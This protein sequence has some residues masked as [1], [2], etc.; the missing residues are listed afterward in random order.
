MVMTQTYF[1]SKFPEDLF[2]NENDMTSWQ[3]AE[4][5]FEGKFD[6]QKDTTLKLI[7]V[8]HWKPGCFILEGRTKDKLGRDVTDI[9][10]FTLFSE[11][12]KALPYPQA[13]WFVPVKTTCEPGEKAVFLVG[14]F[15][16]KD[17]L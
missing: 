4:K 10:Y 7:G 16:R 14:I 5:I 17:A 13:D 3:K 6:T 11:N 8:D 12:D 1:Q 15:Q 9:E 2:N